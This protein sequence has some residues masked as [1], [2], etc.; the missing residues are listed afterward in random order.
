VTRPDGKVIDYTYDSDGRLATITAAA[1]TRTSA[2]AGGHLST[3]SDTANGVSLAY[4]FDGPLQTS[5]TWA[6]GVSG[7]VGWEFNSDFNPSR[8]FAI[9]PNPT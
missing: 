8:E 4:A 7:S 5:V 6:G 9:A 1:G 2:Y 3:L